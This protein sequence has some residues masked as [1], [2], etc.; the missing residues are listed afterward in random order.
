MK[1]GGKSAAIL[2]AEESSGGKMTHKSIHLFHHHS[3]DVRGQM[4]TASDSCDRIIN[5]S[6]FLARERSL[7]LFPVD[8]LKECDP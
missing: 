8:L 3:C 7:V 2:H 4:Q 1:P 5:K 6:H